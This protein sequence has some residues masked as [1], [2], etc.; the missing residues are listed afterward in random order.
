MNQEW[1]SYSDFY[2][3]LGRFAVD[4]EQVC[5]SMEVCIRNILDKSGLTDPG[6]Q[7]VLLSGYNADAL[8]ALLQNLLGRTIKFNKDEKDLCS[9]ALNKVQKLISR[10]NDVIHG[11]WFMLTEIDDNKNRNIFSLGYKL[12]ANSSGLSTKDIKKRKT[13]CKI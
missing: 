12:H 9:R 3:H 5:H 2:E 13:K 11:K 10:R 6:I 8:R 7:E 1:K 4:F